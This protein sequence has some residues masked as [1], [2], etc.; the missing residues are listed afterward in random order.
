MNVNSGMSAWAF[1]R[2]SHDREVDTSQ[3]MHNQRNNHAD[4]A[5][6]QAEKSC[7]ETGQSAFE[8]SGP[9]LVWSCVIAVATT[10][11][12]WTATPT[13]LTQLPCSPRRSC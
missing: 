3:S 4:V 1:Y 2:C 13:R 5:I 8:V 12:T 6:E 7:A 10:S 9:A 11:L